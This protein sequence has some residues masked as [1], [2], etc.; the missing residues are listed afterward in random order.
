MQVVVPSVPLAAVLQGTA[1][2]VSVEMAQSTVAWSFFMVNFT[3]MRLKSY[4]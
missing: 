4:S 1:L 3:T 2:T